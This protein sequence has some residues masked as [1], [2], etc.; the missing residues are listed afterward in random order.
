MTFRLLIAI[1][2]LLNKLLKKANNNNKDSSNDNK[3]ETKILKNRN[4]ENSFFH[5]YEKEEEQQI[6]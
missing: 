3:N 4:K 2:R 5:C 1:E 6:A